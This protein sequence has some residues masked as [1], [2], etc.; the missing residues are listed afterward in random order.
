MGLRGEMEEVRPIRDSQK[1]PDRPIDGVTIRQ[2][3][4]VHRHL[5]AKMSDVVERP[6]RCRTN[7]G[8]HLA[9]DPDERLDE[10]RAHESVR[11]G[12]ERGA[13]PEG[14]PELAPQLGDVGARPAV[15]AR[16]PFSMARADAQDNGASLAGRIPGAPGVNAWPAE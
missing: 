11:P 13:P 12:D 15:R 7:E 9:A 16:H 6:A 10:V 8:V 1:S 2:V 14:I 3:A 4:P 5:P